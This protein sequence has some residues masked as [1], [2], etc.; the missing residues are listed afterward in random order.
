[1]SSSSRRASSGSSHRA[2]SGSDEVPNETAIVRSSP[3]KL[4]LP[5]EEG[6]RVRSA[7]PR[8][9]D[10]DLQSDHDFPSLAS[11]SSLSSSEDDQGSILTA[12][13]EAAMR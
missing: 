4:R 10:F 3:R 8:E 5:T 11:S 12:S 13:V 1:M 2:S 6:L 9:P 7:S